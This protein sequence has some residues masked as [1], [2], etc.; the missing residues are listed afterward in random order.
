MK[1]RPRSNTTARTRRPKD[2]VVVAAVSGGP[3]SVFL[4]EE[5]VR[6]KERGIVIGHVNYGTRGRESEKDQKLVED[7]ARRYCFDV[8]IHTSKISSR[9]SGFEERARDIRRGFLKRL[10]EYSGGSIIAMGHTADDQVE[11]I[12][13]RFFEGAGISGL[14]GIPRNADH[15]IVRPILDIWKEDVVAYLE[16]RRIPY[17]VDRSNRDTRFERNWVRHV[18]IPLLVERYGKSVKKRIFTVGERFRELDEYLGAEAARWIR[19]SV[20]ASPATG[21]L[22]FRRKQYSALPTVLRVKILQEI[23]F[24]HAQV[25]PNER[26][27]RGLDRVLR[28]GGPS[29]EMSV[30]KGWKLANRYENARFVPPGLAAGSLPR[31]LCTE[32]AGKITQAMARRVASKG[33]AE[34]FDASGLRLPLSVRPLRPGDRIRPIGMA[35]ERKLKEI[36]I[37]RKVPREERWGRPV[38]C[39]AEGAILWVPGVVRSAHAPVTAATRC[40]KIIRYLP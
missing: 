7:I 12:L 13:M 16:K 34:A 14:K 31:T 17:R 27:L 4:I 35:A 30:G 36:L 5:L 11:T 2:P 9:R 33:D 6:R 23:C 8:V 19:R 18:L 39:D 38:V 28:S 22:S 15:G 10:S 1:N 26:L 20:K 25:S 40:A 29:A 24:E 32:E 37:D 3:D 21:P